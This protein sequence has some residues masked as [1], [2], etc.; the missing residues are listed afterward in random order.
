MW[1]EE[2]FVTH[3]HNK[4]LTN[5]KYFLEMSLAAFRLP[6]STGVICYE[7][8]IGEKESNKPQAEAFA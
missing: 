8:F 5:V 4:I 1:N 3:G 6:A 7:R 2:T